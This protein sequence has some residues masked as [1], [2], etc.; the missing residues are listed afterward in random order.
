MCVSTAC[1]NQKSFLRSELKVFFKIKLNLK[2][3]SRFEANLELI[4][5]FEVLNEPQVRDESQIHVKSE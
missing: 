5:A 4:C 3:E 2:S 1:Q